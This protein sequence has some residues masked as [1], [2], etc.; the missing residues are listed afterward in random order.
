MDRRTVYRDQI[1]YEMDI[2]YGSR[3]S[4]EGLGLLALDLFGTASK[5]GGLA[6][7]ETGP[8]S[9]NVKVGPGRIY[10]F[11][12]LEATA[13]GV[14]GGTGGLGADTTADHFIVHQ[15][16]R[17]DS[18]NFA[19]TAPATVGHSINYLVQGRMVVADDAAIAAQFY[20]SLNPNAPISNSIS[21]FR[22]DTVEI[23]TKAGTS[24]TTGTQTTPAVDAG[25]IPLWVVTIA[26]GATSIVNANIAAHPSAPTISLGGG[27]G[28][29]PLPTWSF[30]TVANNNAVLANRSWNR[31][32]TAGGAFALK[33]PPTP[34]AGFDV[35]IMGS[36]ATNNL[37]VDRNGSTIVGSAT[38]MVMNLD[39]MDVT[40]LYDGSTWIVGT[41]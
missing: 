15:G 18:S 41:P 21:P 13:W 14:I 8:T 17:R 23:S 36:F 39:N 3:F 27:G 29:T 35:R 20:N 19:L 12:S 16:I 2:L 25:W 28:G 33:L 10:T 38:N 24:A 9:M 1:P 32:T 34:S 22:R 31:P 6:C 4:Q 26:Y 5:F 30:Y 7:T 37:T 40:Y 11:A